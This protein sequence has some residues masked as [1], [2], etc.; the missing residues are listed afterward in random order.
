MKELLPYCYAQIKKY[1]DVIRKLNS[2]QCV[3]SNMHITACDAVA[4]YPN[5]HT[6]QGLALI[7]MALDTFVFKVRPG[8]PRKQTTLAIKI[9][10]KCDVFEFGDTYYKQL[11]GGAMGNPFTCIWAIV[12]Y[13]VIEKLLLSAEL[14]ESILLLVRFI[15]NM[16]I[17]WN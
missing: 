14:K 6:D 16:F 5:I 17:V 13:A 12:H 10:L 8:W 9:L 15:D 7:S 2:F 11:Q 4:M 3:S 1:D